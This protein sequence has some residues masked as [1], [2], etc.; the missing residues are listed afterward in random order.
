MSFRRHFNI[1]EYQYQVG[2]GVSKL[3]TGTQLAGELVCLSVGTL[4]SVGVPVPSR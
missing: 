2:N 4:I 1:W 3:C